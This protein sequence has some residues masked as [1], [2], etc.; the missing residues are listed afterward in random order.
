MPAREL[1]WH[2]ASLQ[3][4]LGFFLVKPQGNRDFPDRSDCGTAVAFGQI[5]LAATVR[6]PACG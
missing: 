4:P 3:G 5:S 1:S 6:T 2:E